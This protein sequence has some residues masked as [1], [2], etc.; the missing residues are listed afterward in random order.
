MDNLILQQSRKWTQTA[1]TIMALFLVLLPSACSD[2][3]EYKPDANCSFDKFCRE[4]PGSPGH[5]YC[6]YDKQGNRNPCCPDPIGAMQWR[7]CKVGADASVIFTSCGIPGWVWCG[8][9]VPDAG[10][11][12]DAGVR[13]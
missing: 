13:Q 2:D 9:G 3:T 10:S 12:Q 5:F 6:D 1:V 8:N 4:I 7:G 11:V